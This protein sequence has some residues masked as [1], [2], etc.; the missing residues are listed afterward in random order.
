MGHRYRVNARPLPSLRRTA[1][2]VFTRQR[3]AVFIDGCFW[4]GCPEHYRQPAAN[5][6]YWIA[7]VDR[8]MKRDADTDASL[9]GAGWTPLRFWTHEKPED[10]AGAIH[11]AVFAQ[12]G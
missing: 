6:Q 1:D 10:V 8:N 12:R 2:L 3:I 5:A 4:H 11:E 9:A 7:K